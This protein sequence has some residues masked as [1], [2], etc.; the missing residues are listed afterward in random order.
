MREAALFVRA[1]FDVP[2]MSDADKYA[3]YDCRQHLD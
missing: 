2:T 3:A 1:T